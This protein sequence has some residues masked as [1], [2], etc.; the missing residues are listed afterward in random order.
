MLATRVTKMLGIKYPIVL[1]PM[2]LISEPQLVSAVSNAGGLGIFATAFLSADEV[3]S[4]IKEIKTLTDLPYGVN[5]PLASANLE[6]VFD[7]L[8]KEDVE[9]IYTSVGNPEVLIQKIKDAGMI[10]MHVV[11]TSKLARKVEELGVDIIVAEGG[12]AGGMLPDNPVSTMTLVPQVVDAVEAPVIA[13]GGIADGRGLVAALSL[14]AEGVL[15]GT[16]FIA[17]KEAKV[18]ENY[19]KAII[20]AKDNDTLLI[21]IGTASL[22][23]LRNKL[24]DETEQKINIFEQLKFTKIA[25]KEGDIENSIIAM[26]QSSGLINEIKS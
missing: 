6:E 2:A 21:K 22:R 4:Q 24:L 8:V 5:I 17:S 13:A 18:H 14:G 25:L 19:K 12:E 1:A 10:H 16:R 11:P 3:K 23:V 9:I 20:N 15:I 7:V 26:G